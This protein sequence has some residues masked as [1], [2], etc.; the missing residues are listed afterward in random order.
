MARAAHRPGVRS[1]QPT[2]ATR[3]VHLTKAHRQHK[4]DIWSLPQ[5]IGSYAHDKLGT[6]YLLLFTPVTLVLGGVAVVGGVY[7]FTRK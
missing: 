6:Y 5:K 2:H 4:F 7:Y 1:L 3:P